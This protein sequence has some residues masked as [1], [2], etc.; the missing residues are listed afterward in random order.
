MQKRLTKAEKEEL[1]KLFDE[2][3]FTFTKLATRF[4]VSVSN[5]SSHFR[6]QKFRETNPRVRRRLYTL[7]ETYFDTLTPNSAY[8]LGLL[9]ADGCHTPSAY[10]INLTL[11]EPDKEIL[12]KLNAELKTNRPLRH[13]V[14]TRKR[15]N[16]DICCYDLFELNINSKKIST[17]L[18]ELGLVQAKSLVLVYPDWLP[19]D[20]HR[21]FIRGYTDGD[22]SL[23]PNQ[24]CITGTFA[25]CTKLA[26]IFEETLKV[27]TSLYRK[28][29]AVSTY[30]VRVSRREDLKKVYK[31]LYS[32]A[33]LC[34]A[35]KHK[36]V[37]ETLAMQ[38]IRVRKSKYQA[39]HPDRLYTYSIREERD[40]R[41]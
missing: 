18:L 10:A 4:G 28:P 33:S 11:A 14:T 16:S 1:Y 25:F 3:T 8:F 34:F 36:V 20:L 15:R 9:Y 35:R 38:P 12:E 23:T 26:Q 40:S 29:K 22:G 27:G 32:D 2:D 21:H 5:I 19:E 41:C 24:L 7:D 13:R 39:L 30:D 17:R 31:W 37:L 6:R